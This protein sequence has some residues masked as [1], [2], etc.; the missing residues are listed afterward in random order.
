MAHS[1]LRTSDLCAENWP[2]V[3]RAAKSTPG[4]EQ[5][6]RLQL[7]LH[8][9]YS[10]AVGTSLSAGIVIWRTNSSLHSCSSVLL[11]HSLAM[12]KAQA[13]ISIFLSLRFGGC[14]MRGLCGA[15]FALTVVVPLVG[16]DP[17]KVKEYEGPVVDKFVGRVVQEGKPVKFPDEEQVAV[18]LTLVKSRRV[19]GIPIK[20]DGTFEITWMP[21]GKYLAS[22]ERRKPGES[23]PGKY[24]LPGDFNIEEGKTEY[25][26]ELGPNWKP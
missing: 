26:F 17:P 4:L 22:L 20:S 18:Q 14:T 13:L 23:R 1:V 25:V 8:W 11:A 15:L 12:V 21:I 10:K 24:S 16:C 5:E 7:A 9:A 19:F 6:A 3:S 2:G